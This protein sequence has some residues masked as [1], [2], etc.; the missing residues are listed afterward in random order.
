METP[1][2]QII[3][4]AYHIPL[5]SFYFL[6]PKRLVQAFCETLRNNAPSSEKAVELFLNDP[7]MPYNF[8]T[9]AILKNIR[10]FWRLI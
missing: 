9:A 5:P 2:D 6:V 10:L 4:G 1:L 7:W 8:C 3:T